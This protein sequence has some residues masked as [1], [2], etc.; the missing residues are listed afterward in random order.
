METGD[1]PLGAV[2]IASRDSGSGFFSLP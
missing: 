2:V 1:E